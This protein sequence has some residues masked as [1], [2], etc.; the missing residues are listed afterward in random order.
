MDEQNTSRDIDSPVDA[1]GVGPS[2]V[3]GSPLSDVEG[4]ALS[5]VEG[6]ALSPVEGRLSRRTRAWL[7][8]GAV[9][10]ALVLLMMLSGS[11]PDPDAPPPAANGGASSDAGDAGLV[12]KDAQLQYTLKDMNGV[13]VNLAS[14]KGK[15]LLINFW[16]T[17]CGPCRV[18]IP[19]LIRLGDEYRA[20]GVELIGVTNENPLEDAAKVK[21]FVAN[22][23]INYR[24]AWASEGFA[25]GLM[26]G[27]VQNVI[28]QSFVITREG[29]VIAHL[30]GF[31]PASTP[32]KLRTAVEQALNYKG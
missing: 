5:N 10:V 8:M 21:D 1:D 4:S 24:I 22:Q 14:F 7:G 20:R 9:L 19:E 29:A 15:V 23:K 26:Q 3:G 13:D 31:N 16:A 17:W 6:P 27:N 11:N 12:G 28:P 30:T 32:Q 18:E 25:L 2:T